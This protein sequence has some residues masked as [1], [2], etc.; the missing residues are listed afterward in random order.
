VVSIDGK[1]IR[2]SRQAGGKAIVHMVSA[3]ASENNLVLGQRKVESKSNEITAIP[4]LLDV[5]HLQGCVITIDAIGCQKTIANKIVSQQ[6]DYI[7]AVK[8]N[9]GELLENLRD[10]FQLLPCKSVSQELDCGHGRVEQRLCSAIADLS[11]VARAAQWTSLQ[12]LVRV[13]GG[14]IL[15]VHRHHRARNSLLHQ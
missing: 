6:A 3:W 7:L 8:E 12:S 9:Q 14:A 1:A 4:K 5:V 2:G 10:S 13:Q 11:M 15:Q